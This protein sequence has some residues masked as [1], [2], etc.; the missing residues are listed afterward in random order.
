MVDSETNDD[1][2]LDWIVNTSYPIRQF[3]MRTHELAEHTNV[4]ESFH[5][6]LENESVFGISRMYG[7]APGELVK[8]N[9]HLEGISTRVKFKRGTILYLPVGTKPVVRA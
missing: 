6:A 7:L 3:R 1:N 9:K 8:I 2:V 5:V 4:A